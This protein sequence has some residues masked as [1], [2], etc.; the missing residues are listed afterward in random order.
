MLLGKLG[1]DTATL[2]ALNL[3]HVRNKFRAHTIIKCL[4]NRLAAMNKFVQ[5]LKSKK[6]FE[7]VMAG[8]DP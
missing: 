7:K 4:N 1:A 8:Q 5:T 6:C 3:R 2:G